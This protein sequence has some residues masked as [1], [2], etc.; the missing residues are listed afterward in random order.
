ML[1]PLRAAFA[2]SGLSFFPS[3]K[4]KLGERPR[5]LLLLHGFETHRFIA[6][7]ALGQPI[8]ETHAS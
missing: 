6:A 5:L 2:G 8:E 4:V 3:A 7:F 1:V